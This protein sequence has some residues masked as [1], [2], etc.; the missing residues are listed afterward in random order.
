[1]KSCLVVLLF[2]FNYTHA[3]E[4]QAEIMV[5]IS[6]YRGD[7]TQH[8]ITL[9]SI[10]PAVNLN[11]K[12]E[13]DNLIIL[14]G[15][16]GWGK[17]SADDKNNKD[18]SLK[19]RNLNFKSAII[20]GSLCVEFNLFDPEFN[21]HYPYIFTGI[22]MFHFNPYTYDKENNKT[23]LQPLGT[24]GQGLSEYPDRKIYKL[25]QFCLLIR[26]GWKM[27]LNQ[28]WDIVYEMGYR[29][30]TTDY[31]DDVSTTY[32]DPQ[33]L[34][35]N[36]RPKAVELTYRRELVPLPPNTEVKRGNPK[37]KDGYFFSGIKLLIHLGREY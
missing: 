1:M 16:L 22:G 31:L 21:Y 9:K 25:T 30:L 15:G 36:R 7:L 2:I 29:F 17:F 33:K 26:G 19:R 18:K 5:G 28:K 14:R 20:E 34:L 11:L 6:G 35:L 13:L 32:A 4:W 10:G 23:Y 12:Y 8:A 3:Q 37:V 27:Q 24:E